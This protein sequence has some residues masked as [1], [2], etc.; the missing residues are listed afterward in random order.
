[1]TTAGRGPGTERHRTRRLL[2]CCSVAEGAGQSVD[3]AEAM[4]EANV[5]TSV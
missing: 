4:A 1:M 5:E 3:A 2:L